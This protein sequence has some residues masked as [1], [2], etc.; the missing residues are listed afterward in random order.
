MLKVILHLFCKL[1]GLVT[2]LSFP[3]LAIPF[4]LRKWLITMHQQLLTQTPSKDHLTKFWG[5]LSAKGG[6]GKLPVHT[7]T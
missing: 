6:Q 5:R 2:F 3:S 4:S 1:I 7:E